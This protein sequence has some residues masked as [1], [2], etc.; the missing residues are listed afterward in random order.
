MEDCNSKKILNLITKL[1]EANDDLASS[2]E[3]SFESLKQVVASCLAI[4]ENIGQSLATLGEGARYRVELIS[5]Q[6]LLKDFVKAI[7]V[8]G[9]LDYPV[10]Q[11]AACL[12]KMQAKL[13]VKKRKRVVFLPYKASMWDSLASIYEAT[14]ADPN[15]D[16][17]VIPLPYYS[18]DEQGNLK[19]FHY[20]GELFPKEVAITSWQEYDLAEKQP[21]VIYIHNSYDGSNFATTVMPAFYSANL[22]KAT[23]LLVYVPYFVSLHEQ[24]HHDYPLAITDGFINADLICVQ[25]EV[26]KAGYL[27]A[28]QEFI[29]KNGWPEAVLAQLDQK[30]VVLGSPKYDALNKVTPAN[31]PLPSDWAK[32]IYRPDGTKKTVVFY[33]T[34][35]LEWNLYG[36]EMFAKYVKV[37]NFFLNHPA[38]YLLIWRPHPLLVDNIRTKTPDFLP[39][40]LRLIKLF[41]EGQI[42]IYDDSP[43]FHLAYAYADAFYGDLSSMAELFRKLG[44][45]VIQQLVTYEP[46]DTPANFELKVAKEL[47][48]KQAV[49]KEAE[50]PLAKLTALLAAITTE[51]VKTDYQFGR[52]IH[53]YVMNLLTG[54]EDDRAF[55]HWIWALKLFGK[56]RP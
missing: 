8:T 17:Y 37:F 47:L 12:A 10:E 18:K 28:W 26:I 53:Q 38:D 35:I 30:M 2:E 55:T 49:I 50:L 15:C 24:A 7:S 42:G 19:D 32:K 43:D 6:T 25:D 27:G 44:R 22:K 9:E 21:D 4:S 46:A 36:Q 45:P 33:N 48:A 41:K 13:R 39:D 40:Y 34:A 51:E 31:Y 16:A 52:K 54:K 11:I 5:Y 14:L 3:L 23:D 56:K 1:Q 29:E 20:E